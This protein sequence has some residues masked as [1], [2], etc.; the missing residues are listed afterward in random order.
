MPNL[1]TFALSTISVITL[2]SLSS[3]P[4]K[5]GF[6]PGHGTEECEYIRRNINSRLPKGVNLTRSVATEVTVKGY[7][8]RECVVYGDETAIRY[9]LN[10]YRKIPAV[11]LSLPNGTDTREGRTLPKYLIYGW[12]GSYEVIE[13]GTAIIILTDSSEARD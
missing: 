11:G 13:S 2:L 10:D 9:A 5:A 7:T 1:K 6:S 12:S 4:A 3:Q 8:G